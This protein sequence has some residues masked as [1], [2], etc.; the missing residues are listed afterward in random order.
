MIEMR[1]PVEIQ[2]QIHVGLF[3]LGAFKPSA[4]SR[5]V[6]VLLL[7]VPEN[8]CH[9]YL[10]LSGNEVPVSLEFLVIPL[11]VI[12]RSEI[13]DAGQSVGL[14]QKAFGQSAIIEPEV[15]PVGIVFREW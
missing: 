5:A 6:P 7:D 2:P 4:A 13:E 14:F 10:L 8:D 15:L 1:L 11:V 9:P 12:E 3:L